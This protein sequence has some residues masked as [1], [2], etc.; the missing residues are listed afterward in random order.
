[1]RLSTIFG[2]WFDAAEIGG[3]EE[4]NQLDRKING[5]SED[6]KHYFVLEKAND[7][8]TDLDSFVK[9]VIECALVVNSIVTCFVELVSGLAKIFVERDFRND[10]IDVMPPILPRQL[11]KLRGR[12]FT[13]II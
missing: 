6:G 11:V 9:D 10:A 12:E 1:M 4:L 3:E 8:L 5:V 2:S 13:N 7:A